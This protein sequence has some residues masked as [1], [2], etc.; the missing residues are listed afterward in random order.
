MPLIIRYLSMVGR[1]ESNP[2]RALITRKLLI[3]ITAKRT[4]KARK[5]NPLY[6]IEL[7][8]TASCACAARIRF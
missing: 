2:R 8:S 5:A 1:R 6:K 3:S 4:R 7:F